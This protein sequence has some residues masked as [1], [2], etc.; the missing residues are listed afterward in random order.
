MCFQAFS[1]DDGTFEGACNIHTSYIWNVYKRHPLSLTGQLSYSIT[2]WGWLWHIEHLNWVSSLLWRHNGRHSVSNHQPHDCLFNRLIR[3]RSKKTPVLCVTGLC[4]GN[5]PGT[6]EFLAQ[7]ASNAQ[8]VSIMDG[9]LCVAKCRRLV[10][11][12]LSV[13]F[14]LL[15]WHYSKHTFTPVPI[16]TFWKKWVTS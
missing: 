1:R 15:H 16:L 4:A 12:D 8:N 13:Y 7:M 9:W 3:R 2:V 11:I 10:S 5:S 14:L 6:G